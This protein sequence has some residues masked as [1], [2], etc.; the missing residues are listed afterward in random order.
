MKL[1]IAAIVLLPMIVLVVGAVRGRV[2]VRSC[3][4]PAEHDRRMAD[5][6]RGEVDGVRAG[7]APA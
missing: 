2:V 7:R 6:F 5:A 3:C 1:V 4:V